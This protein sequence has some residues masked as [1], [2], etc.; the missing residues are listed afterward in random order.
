M[1]IDEDDQEDDG[2]GIGDYDVHG[3]GWKWGW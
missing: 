2:W 3:D 1:I